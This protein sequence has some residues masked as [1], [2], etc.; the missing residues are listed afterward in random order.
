[1]AFSLHHSW[2]WDFWLAHQD[3]V[4]HLYYLH[5]PQGLGDP[6][7]RHRNAVIGHAVSGD[8]RVWE[9]QGTI[10]RP[11]PQGTFDSSATWTGCTVEDDD[12][13]WRL[14]YTG[15]VFASGDS[16]VNTERIGVAT[17]QGPGATDWRKNPLPQVSADPRWYETLA[18]GTWKEEACRDPWV[19]RR[20]GEQHWTM[21]FT[22][23]A[24]PD[25]AAREAAVRGSAAPDLGVIGMAT[26]ADLE[27]WEVGPP[28]SA[29]GSGFLHLE[30]P[31]F[32]DFGGRQAVLFSC[33][34]DHLAAWRRE[35]GD[36]GGIWAAPVSRDGRIDVLDA[37]LLLDQ[38][39]YS[40]RAVESPEGGW[41][42]M[43][44]HH[45]A[46]GEA[47]RGGITDPFPLSWGPD[48]RLH[49]SLPG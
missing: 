41:G 3:G 40:G 28:A 24:A 29:S 19:F 5:A 42:L 33:G 37:Y 20:P 2:V 7:L 43:A 34:G 26:S 46:P 12:G 38:R 15:S 31:Q 23:R 49:V 14:F 21:Y 30:V 35:Q 36:V 1:M 8:L 39:F 32:V 9:D 45:P 25:Q 10:L 22:A 6:G 27:T 13:V 16:P 17:A 48:G 18:D 11:G 47:F 4:H 44:F